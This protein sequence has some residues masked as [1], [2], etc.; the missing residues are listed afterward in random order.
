MEFTGPHKIRHFTWRACR[1]IL[2]TKV[3]LKRRKVVDV[4]SCEECNDGIENSGHLF[5]SCQRARQIWQCTKLCFA[6]EP[7][8]IHSFFDLVWHLMMREEHD[9]DKMATMVTLASPVDM[10]KSQ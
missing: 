3:N 7:T 8:A 2:P 9:E 10:D 5:W 6:S 1:E 4:D